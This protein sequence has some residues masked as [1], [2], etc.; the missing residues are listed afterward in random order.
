MG[1]ALFFRLP[2]LRVA[3]AWQKRALVLRPRDAPQHLCAHLGGCVYIQIYP[4]Y[5]MHAHIDMYRY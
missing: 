1:G 2:A 4:R 3:G 5:G